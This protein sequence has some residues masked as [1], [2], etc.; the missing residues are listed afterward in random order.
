M[1]EVFKP[2]LSSPLRSAGAAALHPVTLTDLRKA[3]SVIGWRQETMGAVMVVEE[4]D[5]EQTVIDHGQPRPTS[6]PQSGQR[7][8]PHL[9]KTRTTLL[10]DGRQ[11]DTFSDMSP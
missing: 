2:A 9:Q 6:L 7:A 8:K 4:Q 5:T 10:C 3:G 11:R 1:L